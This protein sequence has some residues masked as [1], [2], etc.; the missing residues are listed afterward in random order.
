MKT[1]KQKNGKIHIIVAEKKFK[2]EEKK[3]LKLQWI[4]PANER[5]S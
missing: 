4:T 3:A 2:K 5:A 1:L